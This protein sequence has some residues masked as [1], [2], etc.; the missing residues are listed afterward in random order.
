[1][2]SRDRSLLAN[3]A[4]LLVC[5]L[6]AGLVVAA[7][8]FPAV[9]MG[10]LAAKAGADTFDSLPTNLEEA[11]APQITQV[12]AADGKTLLAYIYDENRSDIPLS[13]V[14]E[15]MKQ[16]IVASEDARYYKH[17][18][19]DFKGVARAFVANQQNGGV[20]QGASTLTMQTVRQIISYTAKSPKE[21]LQATE[22][23]PARKLR[24]IKLALALEK[25]YNKDQILEKY[26]NIASFGHGAFGINAASRVYFDKAPKDLKV[27]EAALLAGLVKA[28]TSFDPADPEK[29]PAALERR[30]YVLKQM[31]SLKYITQAQADEA[32]KVELKIVGKRTPNECT[33]VLRPDLNAGFFCDY[34]LRWWNGNKEFGADGYERNNKLR[35]A[36]YRL[37][38]SLDINAQA[39]AMRNI[40]DVMKNKPASQAMMLSG[41]EPNTGRIQLLAVN[42]NFSN[43]QTN[44]GLNTEPSKKA[45]GV[46]GNYPSTTVPLLTGGADLVGYQ[47]GSVFKEFTILAALEKG[48]PLDYTIN[49]VSPYPS[50]FVV[51]AGQ[52]GAC[53]GT[54]FYCPENS[55]KKG[56]GVRNMWTGLG[57]SINTYFVPLE[58]RVGV[59]KVVG[60]AQRLGL[61]FK[62]ETDQ[63]QIKTN[64]TNWGAFTL[65]VS[66]TTPLEMSNVFATLAADGVYCKPTPILE[67]RDSKGNKIDAGKPDCK[68][69]L[70]PDIAR[71][72]I[73]A[74]RCPIGDKSA[75]DRCEGK[76][77]AGDT[78]GIVGYPIA[79]KT[80]T[81]D[82]E[83]SATLTVTTRQLA[84]SGFYTD[85]D[86]PQTNQRFEH[87]GGVNPVV[88]RTMR[89][90]MKGKPQVGFTAPSKDIAFGQ[91]QGIPGVKC[92]TVEQARNKIRGAGFEVDVQQG[93]IASDCPPG[94]VAKTDPEGTTVKGGVVVL[95]ISGGPGAPPGGTGGGGGGGGGPGPGGGGGGGGRKCKPFPRLCPPPP[96]PGG[97]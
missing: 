67:I 25:K 33:E 69:V 38:T 6:L 37:I 68:K 95:I 54:K 14:G 43:D 19:V 56:A 89:D 49:T 57:S 90:A 5:G 82:D 71:G 47:A 87:A 12:Y 16:A 81:T 46:K 83:K 78:R 41:I 36:G 85:P 92:N 4:S 20:A 79:G 18:G 93:Q 63:Q 74:A 53:S 31:V 86:W 7:A 66:S 51:G 75:Y 40:T 39:A 32:Q 59:D 58:E 13:E 26:L 8:A 42:R 21:V 45:R 73:D 52:P 84:I 34:L 64:L 3:A 70:E 91:R 11:T 22:D 96:P 48:L 80:G 72:G 88:Q 23:T 28:P 29:R 35:S 17:H 30:Q 15:V 24:E 2:R 61:E 55:G 1:M 97:Q 62:S 76:S 94:T 10:G 44:N 50:K 77:T 60:M 65:G 9:A 27:E